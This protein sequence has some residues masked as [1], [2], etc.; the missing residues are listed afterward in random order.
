LVQ[1]EPLFDDWS[2]PDDTFALTPEDEAEVNQILFGN[3]PPQPPQPQPPPPPPPAGKKS[4]KAKTGDAAPKAA[5]RAERA[6]RIAADW[7]LSDKNRQWA[8]ENRPDIDIDLEAKKFHNHFLGVGGQ[9]ARRVDWDATW[10][11]WAL[12]A[13]GSPQPNT[14]NGYSR[15]TSRRDPLEILAI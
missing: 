2:F 11:K 4:R 1:A 13:W 7:T 6:T 15:H 8:K 3:P 12:N 10:R 5:T 14:G 9:A